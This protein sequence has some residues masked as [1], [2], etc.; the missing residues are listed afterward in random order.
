MPLYCIIIWHPLCNITQCIILYTVCYLLHPKKRLKAPKTLKMSLKK[1][2]IC[3][4]FSLNLEKFTPD[5]KILHR[6]RLWCLWQIWGM[7]KVKKK[8]NFVH[9]QQFDWDLIWVSWLCWLSW[10]GILDATFAVN[11]FLIIS[12]I[13]TSLHHDR[14][15]IITSWLIL[16]LDLD[17]CFAFECLLLLLA[18]FSSRKCL[19][20][21]NRCSCKEHLV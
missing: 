21:A 4:F 1:S 11:S 5:R 6:H 3:S 2:N 13:M 19:L 20:N 9:R 14:T 10:H 15:E 8:S 12:T 7:V 18:R 16:R 17:W